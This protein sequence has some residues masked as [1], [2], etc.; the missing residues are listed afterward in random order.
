M[1]HI[2][3]IHKPPAYVSKEAKSFALD[4]ICEDYQQIFY[5]WQSWLKVEQP[6]L[7]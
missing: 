6:I 1:S 5:R 3:I 4:P 2:A 7:L